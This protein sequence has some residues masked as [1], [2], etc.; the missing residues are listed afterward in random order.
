V[1]YSKRLRIFEQASCVAASINS[2]CMLNKRKLIDPVEIG[3]KG[4]RAR[5][6]SLSASELQES[7]PERGKD[8]VECL[9][10]ASSGKLPAKK[11]SK[12]TE[13]GKAQPQYRP[14][15]GSFFRGL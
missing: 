6:E 9:L 12:E 2:G 7:G 1:L 4:G 15:R 11:E 14:R 5:A 10:S 3:S 13:S 8:Q